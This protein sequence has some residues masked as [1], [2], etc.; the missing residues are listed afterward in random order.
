MWFDLII[1]KETLLRWVHNIPSLNK[2]SG[3]KSIKFFWWYFEKAMISWIHSD[4]IWP[5]VVQIVERFIELIKIFQICKNQRTFI[6]FTSIT[7]SIWPINKIILVS[8]VLMI[9]KV[10]LVLQEACAKCFAVHILKFKIL[11]ITW[12]NE[13][14]NIRLLV[15]IFSSINL[16]FLLFV[17]FFDVVCKISNFDMWTAKHLAQA[18]CTDLTLLKKFWFHPISQNRNENISA[19]VNFNKYQVRK[20]RK[21]LKNHEK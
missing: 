18:S 3:Q 15:F 20:I 19:L 11:Q 2:Y 5:L 8:I 16:V 9:H 1:L 4:F 17:L 13:T 14:K 12:K 7:A 21:L 10:N 6:Y